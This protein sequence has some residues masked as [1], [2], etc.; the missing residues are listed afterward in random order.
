MPMNGA[1][2]LNFEE[3]AI[4][5]GNLTP[6]AIETDLIDYFSQFGPVKDARVVIDNFAGRYLGYGFVTFVD[7]KAMKAGV[8]N[9]SHFLYGRSLTVH[10]GLP[11]D[12][13]F[14]FTIQSPERNVEQ[15]ASSNR[16]YIGFRPESVNM[17]DLYEYFSN[18][19]SV[20]EI[21]LM[22]WCPVPGRAFVVFR[23]LNSADSVLSY[24]P[25]TINGTQITVAGTWNALSACTGVSHPRIS[26]R[27][28]AARSIT[29]TKTGMPSEGASKIT[30]NMSSIY[31]GNLTPDATETDLLDYF[32]KF[33][34]VKG[35]RVVIDSFTG[36][37][38]GYG[39][40]TFADGDAIKN[41]VLEVC[42][43]LNGCRLTVRPGM[44]SGD[45]LAPTI[46]SVSHPRISERNKAARS[47]TLTKTGMP[48][49]GASKITSN[50][51]PIYVGNLT[52]D[53]T[54]TDLLDYFSKFGHVKGARVVIDSFTG[55]CLGYGFV[56]FADGDAIKNGV[57]EVCHFLNG[58]RLTVRPGM[59]SG[60]SLA[61]TIQSSKG[62][63]KQKSDSKKIYL[64]SLP[65]SVKP[66]DL[67]EY[68]SKF[69]VI[70]HA[71]LLDGHKLRGCGFVVLRDLSLARTVLQSQP[72]QIN[73]TQ[74]TVSLDR[75]SRSADTR[76]GKNKSKKNRIYIKSLPESVGKRDLRDYFSK[77]G[78]IQNVRVSNGR[79]NRGSGFVVFRELES[80]R[81]VL[82]SQP[83]QL[84]ETQITVTRTKKAPSAGTG[85][86]KEVTGKSR[87]NRIPV[88]SLPK[89]VNLCGPHKHCS[90]LSVG[91]EIH[92]LKG[93]ASR[94]C[95][96]MGYCVFESTR[97]GKY[98]RKNGLSWTKWIKKS[99]HCDVSSPDER[100]KVTHHTAAKER[101]NDA[102]K[103]TSGKQ[104]IF[105]APLTRD[106]TEADLEAYFSKFGT[107]R[108]AKII[109]DRGTGVSRGFGFVTFA[110]S[111]A[112]NDGVLEACHFLHGRRLNVNPA[113]P[114]DDFRSRRTPLK[115]QSKNEV[116]QK[117]APN[118]IYIGSLPPAVTESDLHE[119][120]SKFGLVKDVGLVDRFKSLDR[121]FIVFR[122][123]ESATKVIE[124][125]PHKLN[126]RKIT[127]SLTEEPRSTDT[128]SGKELRQNMGPNKIY[129]GSLPKSVNECC[130]HEYFSK[131]GIVM[132]VGVL[133]ERQYCGRGFVDFL[134]S[135][136]PIRV[137]QSQPHQIN[138]TQITVFLDRKTGFAGTGS[139][140]SR[141][142]PQNPSTETHAA[143]LEPETS[144][145]SESFA[146][147]PVGETS[148]PAL[149][150]RELCSELSSEEKKL[151]RAYI[152]RA[153][154]A[155]KAAF[156]QSRRLAQQRLQEIQDTWLARK[157]KE[158]RGSTDR[159]ETKD[160][161]ATIEALYD[162]K[163]QEP[164]CFSTRWINASDEEVVDS[165]A[166]IVA[167]QRRP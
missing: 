11:F 60:D 162:Q 30:S 106:T 152:D 149:D 102:D 111:E 82:H 144:P 167:F 38:L 81:K 148:G 41:G 90:Q 75:K 95:C 143:D 130:L 53:A 39:F 147:C 34:H 141:T 88:R 160:F 77:F 136:S 37:C 128:G 99:A 153:S 116:T 33:G 76:K 49:E 50:M 158:I 62:N 120:F 126:R 92:M 85:H 115:V 56:T 8:L 83:H 73:E 42:H 137:L 70:E 78:S 107:V 139:A 164:R 145:R 94:S 45:S 84:S 150:V 80:V 43:F 93:R 46:Q 109:T 61:P 121:G 59:P 9:F 68:F 101:N 58:C 27:N 117:L 165:Q 67:H 159:N 151:D 113:A 124:S 12:D 156:Y 20:K 89:S 36:Q 71:R 146:A 157:A 16:I 112:M 135:D 48:S 122:D 23:D 138:E 131:F 119:Y 154:D 29:L 98:V 64:E 3:S 118:R 142:V 69:G 108:R 35:A 5:V 57:L 161:F 163:T 19:G 105:V 40:V 65:K 72:H 103:I 97:K 28:K 100:R 54:E 96:F 87:P 127:V 91:D 125:Q 133:K 26:E 2:K 17:C 123:L 47:I 104:T 32:S 129:L 21:R 13:S 18:F 51:S 1:C 25:H 52:P 15:K 31:V 79:R 10:L 6:K 110:D 114:R 74:I 22:K 63:V 86:K 44:P 4:C 166:L 7:G 132:D 24:Q 14:A 155:N 134:N 55:Q 66:C 140:N